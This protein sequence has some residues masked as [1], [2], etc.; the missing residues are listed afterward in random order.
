LREKCPRKK[1]TPKSGRIYTA[2]A[3]ILLRILKLLLL[4]MAEK[5]ELIQI[6]HYFPLQEQQYKLVLLKYQV[7]VLQLGLSIID[8]LLLIE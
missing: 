4:V 7:L 5:S 2:I 3:G 8:K 6:D 1:S